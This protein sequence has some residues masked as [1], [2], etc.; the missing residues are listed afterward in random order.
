MKIITNCAQ[1]GCVVEVELPDEAEFPTVCG[2]CGNPLVGPQSIQRVEVSHAQLGED[3]PLLAVA[4]DGAPDFEPVEFGTEG[5]PPDNGV[6][7][8]PS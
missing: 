7:S 4:A 2:C 1:R 3:G 6:G 5:L 8:F